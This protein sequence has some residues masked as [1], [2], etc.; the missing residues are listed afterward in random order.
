[1]D[2]KTDGASFEAGVP[3]PLFDAATLNV[4]GTGGA[5]GFAV[6]RDG[7]RFL[8]IAPVEKEASTPLE[9]LVNWR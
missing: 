5:S 9:V 2:V 7:Q 6:P 4:G 1:M 3:K 8:A